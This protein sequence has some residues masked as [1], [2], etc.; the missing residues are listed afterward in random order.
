MPIAIKFKDNFPLVLSKHS[1]RN[2]FI[3][4]KIKNSSTIPIKLFFKGFIRLFEK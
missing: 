1:S 4:F 2:P 3:L